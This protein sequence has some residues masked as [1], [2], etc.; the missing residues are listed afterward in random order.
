MI[1]TNDLY[2]TA[3]SANKR[4]K[5]AA[6]CYLRLCITQAIDWV[7][8]I[9]KFLE[10]LLWVN[11]SSLHSS[12]L[13]GLRFHGTPLPRISSSSQN[14]LLPVSDNPNFYQTLPKCP[15]NM[16]I[17]LILTEIKIF[18]WSS[19]FKVSKELFVVCHSPG[20]PSLNCF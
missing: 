9:I 2:S 18:F 7:V 5:V 10:L 17:L 1:L 8:D 16:N 11:S 3:L 15:A 4:K 14:L 12:S 13:C 19:S 6:S 20:I